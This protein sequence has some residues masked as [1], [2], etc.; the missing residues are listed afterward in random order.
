MLR[1]IEKRLIF[2]D[3]QDRRDFLSRLAT[4]LHRA[5][6]SC[7]AWALLPNHVHLVLKTKAESLASLMASLNTGYA[8]YFNRRHARVGH[9]FQNRFRSRALLDDADLLGIVL[10]VSGNH[11]KHGMV[12]SVEELGQSPWCSYGALMGY[13]EPQPFHQAHQAL[14]LF[15]PTTKSARVE[16]GRW[17]TER[18]ELTMALTEAAEIRAPTGPR[19]DLDPII[20]RVCVEFGVSQHD[21][22]TGM[23]VPDVSAARA[24][25]THIASSRGWT[26][27]ALAPHLGV[28]AAAL[29]QARRRGKDLV[30]GRDGFL[31]SKDRPL[32]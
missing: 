31:V 10:Y 13:T 12:S 26:L 20:E 21:L 14:E 29:C 24:A 25:I 6:T 32:S 22:A 5:H 23:R 3:D 18:W 2:R 27:V 16:L 4:V 8:L 30:T 17:M 28:S 19:S 1:G 15:G 11:L 7:L 9:L